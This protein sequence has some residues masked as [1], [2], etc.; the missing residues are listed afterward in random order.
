MSSTLMC[1][2][3]EGAQGKTVRHQRVS[4]HH[5]SSVGRV[6]R[7]Y[8]LTLSG[9]EVCVT[10]AFGTTCAVHVEDCEGW[11]VVRLLAKY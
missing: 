7:T 3:R 5:L 11:C 1:K 6:L 10:E 4:Y 2:V 9:W 8:Y